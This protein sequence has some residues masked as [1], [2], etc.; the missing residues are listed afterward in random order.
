M[1]AFVLIETKKGK[2]SEV[3]EAVRRLDGVISVDAVT[4]PYDAIAIVQGETMREIGQ[5]V[6]EKVNTNR[7]IYRTMTSI[8][9]T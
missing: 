3:I 6:K 5:I 7:G 2:V 8:A 1:K 9:L 4:G